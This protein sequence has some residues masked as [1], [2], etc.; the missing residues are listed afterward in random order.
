MENHCNITSPSISNRFPTPYNVFFLKIAVNLNGYEFP[1]L[2][3]RKRGK[4]KQ[5]CGLQRSV[6]Q[7]QQQIQY[8]IAESGRRLHPTCSRDTR[9]LF[10]N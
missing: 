2:I 9:G 3:S 7:E 4:T 6:N 5:I 8:N 1:L 10:N